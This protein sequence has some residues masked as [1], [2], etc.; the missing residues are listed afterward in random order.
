MHVAV[1][2]WG[3]TGV[4]GRAIS[5]D[6]P[7][8]VWY[9]TLFT[10]L[11]MAALLFYRKQWV[12]IV[13]KDGWTLA[14]VGA[15]MGLHWVCF[16]GSIQFGNASVALVCL[17]I[18][19][20]FTSLVEPLVNKGRY[21]LVEILLGVIA[22]V[23]VYLISLAQILFIKGIIFGLVAA[24]LASVFTILNKRVAARYPARTMVFYEM[25][26]G[27]VTVSIV[28]AVLMISGQQSYLLSP[29]NLSG[30]LVLL[31]QG[32]D[33]LWLFVLALC[34]TVWAQSLAL[35][36]LKVLSSF[37]SNLTVNLEPVY[38][39]ILAFIF[40]Q[41]NKELKPGFYI[42]VALI[43]VSVGLQMLRLLKPTH[44]PGYVAEKGGVD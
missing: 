15:L 10:A 13:R 32:Y 35:N 41:E 6:A 28:I 5:V 20:V 34:C 30:A 24:M 22:L 36:A 42:G 11:M 21:N 39:M 25:T 14:A 4:L 33:W 16:Y 38:G 40:Y 7:V 1:L 23:G 44:S 37:T 3:F 27:W 8:L 2:L 12:P 9:R 29:A 43:M 26:A 19:P 18:S 17:S 31:P